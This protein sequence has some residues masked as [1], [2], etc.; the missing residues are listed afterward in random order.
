MGTSREGHENRPSGRA[1]RSPTSTS[2]MLTRRA[3]LT[4]GTSRG[5]ALALGAL[6]D[7]QTVR[8]AAREMKLANV[9]E[10][11]T[12]CNFCSCGCGMVASVRDGKLITL[13]G[14]FD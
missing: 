8:A 2:A 13:E 1:D 14:D 4:G 7:V 10:Y 6:V 9:S 3:W 12:A 11:T 5:A